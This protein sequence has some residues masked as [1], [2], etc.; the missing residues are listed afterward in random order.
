MNIG[1]KESLNDHKRAAA[2]FCK[3]VFAIISVKRGWLKLEEKPGV[4]KLIYN[5]GVV[6]AARF[7]ELITTNVMQNYIWCKEGGVAE[8]KSAKVSHEAE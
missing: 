1:F 4:A 3:G 8:F 5:T 7:I 2:M 6:S